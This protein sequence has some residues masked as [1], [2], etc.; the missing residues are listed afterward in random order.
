[1]RTDVADARRSVPPLQGQTGTG[2]VGRWGLL[3]LTQRVSVLVPRRR[4]MQDAF[5]QE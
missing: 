2:S 3:R 4:S 1:M 5:M